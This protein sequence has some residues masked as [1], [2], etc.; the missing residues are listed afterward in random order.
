MTFPSHPKGAHGRLQRLT[1]PTHLPRSPTLPA[2]S[3]LRPKSLWMVSAHFALR[4]TVSEK[5][6]LDHHQFWASNLTGCFKARSVWLC[7]SGVWLHL[8]EWD[9]FW[10]FCSYELI[11]TCVVVTSEMSH[12][13]FGCFAA[14]PQYVE[15]CVVKAE[16]DCDSKWVAVFI[17]LWSNQ[18]FS[19]QLLL[20]AEFS[21]G[22]MFIS[23]PQ[24]PSL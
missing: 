16:E 15:G 14:L 10:T 22:Q 5:C 13:M 6:A 1:A 23:L 9:S 20:S 24:N 19:L 18:H 12:K 21:S 4:I 2:S 17:V 7:L 3:Q 8:V 11:W